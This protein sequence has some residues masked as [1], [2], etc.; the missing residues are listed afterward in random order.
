MK[1][2]LL[3]GFLLVFTSCTMFLGEK[4][5]TYDES[6]PYI[7]PSHSNGHLIRENERFYI[8]PIEKL[9][10]CRGYPKILY[11]GS[12]TNYSFFRFEVMFKYEDEVMSIALPDSICSNKY[13]N[14]IDN[15][16]KINKGRR[17]A[18]IVDNKMVVD[19]SLFRYVYNP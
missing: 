14:T 7:E 19:D 17:H 4:K 18:K 9:K 13:P 2:I 8:I 11:L 6:T 3:I 5:L 16:I 15:E 1:Y 10:K 12:E